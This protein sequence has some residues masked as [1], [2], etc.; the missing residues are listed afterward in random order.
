MSM[1]KI[2]AWM[3]IVVITTVAVGALVYALRWWALLFPVG[4][5]LAFVLDWAITT[6]MGSED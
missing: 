2:I 5:S 3:L 4:I 1:K 6:V